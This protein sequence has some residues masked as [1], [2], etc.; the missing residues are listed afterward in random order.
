MRLGFRSLIIAM[1]ALW[2]DLSWKQVAAAVGW[3]SDR[4]SK[5]LRREEI[6]EKDFERLLPHVRSRP[7]EVLVAARCIEDLEALERESNLTDEEQEEVERGVLEASRVLRAVLVDRVRRSRGVPAWNEYPDPSE[8]ARAG[9][10]QARQLWAS[11]SDPDRVLEGSASVSGTAGRVPATAGLDSLQSGAASAVGVPAAA[12]FYGRAAEG[13]ELRP[14]L[15]DER[16]AAGRRGE[17]RGGEGD[18]D[19]GWTHENV[20]RAAPAP[21]LPGPLGPRLHGMVLQEGGKK[22]LSFLG[23][24][25]LRLKT[26]L[27]RLFRALTG[28]TQK[29]FAEALGLE[30]AVVAQYELGKHDPGLD[31]LERMA[32]EADLTVRDGEEALRFLEALRRPRL[33]AGLGLG[34]LAGDLAEVVARVDQRLLR[35]PFEQQAPRAEDRQAVE[36]LWL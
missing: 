33:R 13:G 18:R 6:P 19:K 7:A 11:G 26:L 16:Q 31:L 4:L 10:E 1:L 8:A 14:E 9:M 30:P 20:S 5:I 27:V 21:D 32:A 3:T 15:V 29:E 22:S 17:Q 25:R 23:A 35:L 28:K 2:R 24:A 34:D 12:F 36:G